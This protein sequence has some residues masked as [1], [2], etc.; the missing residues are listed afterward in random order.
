MSPRMI[1]MAMPEDS[2]LQAA[3]GRVAVRHG[4]MDH[5]LRMT[6]KSICEVTPQEALLATNGSMSGQLRQRIEKLARKRFGDG[7]ALVK[8]QAILRRCQKLSGQRNKLLHGVFAR[9][10]D[11]PDLFLEDG[12]DPGPPPTVPELDAL[13]S[14]LD[15]VINELNL[16]RIEGFLQEALTQSKPI[17][18]GSQ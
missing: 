18:A 5:I 6:I 12:Y 15:V 13:C 4:Q 17:K 7:P 16:A 8:L 11:G 14:E 1:Y 2:E 9:E 10:L 3:I